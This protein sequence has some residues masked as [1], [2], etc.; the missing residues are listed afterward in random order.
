MESSAADRPFAELLERLAVPAAT[1]PLQDALAAAATRKY[2]AVAALNPPAG[3]LDGWRHKLPRAFQ[4]VLAW[5]A[6]TL[7][8]DLQS[9][10]LPTP[11]GDTLD[12]DLRLRFPDEEQARLGLTAAETVL[13]FLKNLSQGSLAEIEKSRIGR[14]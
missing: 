3:V 10:A 2:K 13:G 9:T 6:A 5:D 4:P 8:L 14:A 11:F 1:G 7:A 12:V